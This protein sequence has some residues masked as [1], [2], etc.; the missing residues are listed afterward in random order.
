MAHLSLQV[1]A[2]LAGLGARVWAEHVP[3]ADNPADVLSRGGFSDPVVH[4]HILAGRWVYDL[5][6]NPTPLLLLD[7]CRSLATLGCWRPVG[8]LS[9]M[10]DLRSALKER[11]ARCHDV[12][13]RRSALGVLGAWPRY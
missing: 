9:R 10:H 2:I 8:P 4:A 3:S 1:H 12:C 5:P 11:E 6:Q 13:V 7:I